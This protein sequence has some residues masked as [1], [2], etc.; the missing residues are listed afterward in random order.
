MYG[1]EILSIPLKRGDKWRTVPTRGQSGLGFF[2]YKPGTI[3]GPSWDL[4]PYLTVA[5]GTGDI[6]RL[7][8]DN[9]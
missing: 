4:G 7:S 8:S 3:V 1:E 5:G 9:E 2:G 6:S